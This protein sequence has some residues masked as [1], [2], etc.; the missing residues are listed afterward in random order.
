MA[1]ISVEDWKWTC[2]HRDLHFTTRSRT[3][4]TVYEVSFILPTVLMMSETQ[5]Y[6][7]WIPR[8]IERGGGGGERWGKRERGKCDRTRRQKAMNE[9]IHHCP[10]M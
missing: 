8:Q 10:L 5:L 2:N 6:R 7:V 9:R 3:F 1:V 4:L